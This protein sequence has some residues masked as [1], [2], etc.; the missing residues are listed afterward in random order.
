[1]KV[2]VAQLQPCG[3]CSPW[4]SPGPNTG[5]GSL[6][7]PQ[8]ISPTQGCN[9]GLPNCR[10]ILYQLSHQESPRGG[11]TD[12]GKG[13]RGLLLL[14]GSRSFC[15]DPAPSVG[16]PL[17]PAGLLLCALGSSVNCLAPVLLRHGGE[18]G[19]GRPWSRASPAEAGA[20]EPAML[21][22]ASQGRSWPHFRGGSLEQVGLY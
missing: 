8:V 21:F 22:A 13:L 15:G 5:V 9:P 1:M 10:R 6:S 19:C 17:R 11:D 18:G 14:R 2:K 16:V 3:L 4:T 7:L 20:L 12:Q